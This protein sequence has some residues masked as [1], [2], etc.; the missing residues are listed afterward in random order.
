MKTNASALKR[1]P[2]MTIALSDNFIIDRRL[3]RL[4][5]RCFDCDGTCRIH[6][7]VL[8]ALSFKHAQHFQRC[9]GYKLSSPNSFARLLSADRNTLDSNAVRE[10]SHT[11]A[12]L[13]CPRPELN[14]S[15]AT[16]AGLTGALSDLCVRSSFEIIGQLAGMLFRFSENADQ[17][18]AGY[19]IPVAYLAN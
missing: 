5:A 10:W 16:A 17:H 18:V 8:H 3:W 12:E 7:F 19:K 4:Q 6:C 15:A 14:G 2:A 13:S 1:A 11:D 9:D